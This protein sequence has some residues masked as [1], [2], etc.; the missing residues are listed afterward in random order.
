MLTRSKTQK[1]RKPRKRRKP[2]NFYLRVVFFE[3]SILSIGSKSKSRKSKWL[4][5]N[6]RGSRRF[7]DFQDFDLA[8]QYLCKVSTDW[9]DFSDLLDLRNSTLKFLKKVPR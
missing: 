6:F 4:E 5:K 9:A 1:P 8:P 3:F 7:R 2:R